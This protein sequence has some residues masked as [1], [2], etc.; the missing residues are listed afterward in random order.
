[1][2]KRVQGCAAKTLAAYGWWVRRFARE[3][4]ALTA[5]AVRRFFAALEGYS[6]STRHQAYRSVKTWALWALSQ[7]V[8]TENPFA[9]FAVRCP[10]TLPRV[11]TDDEVRAVLA[12]CPD[13]PTGKR[14]RAVLLAMADA[15]VRAVK[16]A[17]CLSNRGA[18][19]S[20]ACSCGRG[21]GARTA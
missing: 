2:D 10:R 4:P 5:L 19:A 11:P 6:D 13:T 9:A 17:A 16:C 20:A 21:R 1:M 12:V 14:N 7:G 3:Q 18:P 8:I 15:G